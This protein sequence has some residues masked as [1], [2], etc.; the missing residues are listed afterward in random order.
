MWH[1]GDHLRFRALLLQVAP[2]AGQRTAGAQPGHEQVDLRQVA[3]N[4]RACRLVV[5]AAVLHAARR[6]LA[7]QLG[8]YLDAGLRRE[9]A[10]ADKR[11][12]SDGFENRGVGHSY[13]ACCMRGA[14]E[15]VRTELK[16]C[17]PNAASSLKRPASPNKRS[18][19][20]EKG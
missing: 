14:L 6:V 1:R 2:D 18:A 11:R 17:P 3:Q 16:L 4:L 12:V 15:S 20:P 19:G 13:Y 8:V 10:Q 9:A 5:S 7:L